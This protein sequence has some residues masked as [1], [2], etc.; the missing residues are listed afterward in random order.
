MNSTTKSTIKEA[1]NEKISYNKM[2]DLSTKEMCLGKFQTF[3]K[4]MKS[5]SSKPNNMTKI[6][7]T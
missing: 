7:E 2:S 4:H 5:A 6:Y 3:L 1:E